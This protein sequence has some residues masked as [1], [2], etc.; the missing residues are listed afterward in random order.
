L[1]VFVRLFHRAGS[2]LFLAGFLAG[3]ST[4]PEMPKFPELTYGHLGVMKFDTEQVEIVDE[5]KPPFKAPNIEHKVPAP[6]A[7]AMRRWAIDR[8]AGAGNPDRRAVFT[9]QQAAITESRLARTDGLRGVVTTDQSERYDLTLAAR[10]ELFE[11][12]TRVGI[13]TASIT[14]S[15]TVAEDITL[16]DRDKVLFDMVEN[17]MLDFNREME[18]SVSQFLRRYMR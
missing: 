8:L 18:V 3:C 6:P 4:A 1:P 10:F 13:A 9:I 12:R 17:A 14:R 16:N 15:R 2:L 5:Y 11:G 7:L